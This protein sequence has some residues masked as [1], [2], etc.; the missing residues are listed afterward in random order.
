MDG[1]M[2]LKFITL[3]LF[4]FGTDQHIFSSFL[5]DALRVMPRTRF[6]ILPTCSRDYLYNV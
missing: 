4:A 3:A 6:D 1:T 2:E 5:A